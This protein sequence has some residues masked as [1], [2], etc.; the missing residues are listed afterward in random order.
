MT[1]SPVLGTECLLDDPTLVEEFRRLKKRDLTE[2]YLFQIAC[3]SLGPQKCSA[4]RKHIMDKMKTSPRPQ[5]KHLDARAAMPASDHRG[6]AEFYSRLPGDKPE[7]L[8]DWISDRKAFR[9]ALERMGDLRRWLRNKPILTD[10]EVLVMERDRQA[11]RMSSLPPRTSIVPPTDAVTSPRALRRELEEVKR[12]LRMCEPCNLSKLLDWNGTGKLKRVDLS[13]LFKK[14]G[15]SIHPERLNVLMSSLNSKDGNS[16]TVEVL[17]ASIQ[18]WSRK[19]EENEE[20]QS[21]P[22]Y[23]NADCEGRIGSRHHLPVHGDEKDD[24]EVLQDVE[25]LAIMRRVLAATKTS[26]PSSLSGPVGREVDRFRRLCFSEYLKSLEQCQRQGLNVSQATLQKVLLHPGDKFGGYF[27]TPKTHRVEGGAHKG[28]KKMKKHP[29]CWVDPNAF[30][31]G[32]EDHVRLFLPVMTSSPA[33]VLFQRIEHTVV[34]SPGHW[35][36]NHLG[37]STSGDIEAHK[38]YSL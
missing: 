5:P 12:F 23:W 28:H 14:E 29:V 30:W 32:R 25:V 31:P 17:A 20:Q 18:A 8:L 19:H 38:T 1:K 4:F 22:G 7:E 24:Q 21:S 35:P 26:C 27:G 33:M 9:E 2:T 13:A 34:P 6:A 37:Y 10:M 15:F 36:V 16:V 11:K 3:G